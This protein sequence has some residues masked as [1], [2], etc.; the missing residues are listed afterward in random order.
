MYEA[1]LC[2]SILVRSN[3]INVG[4]VPVRDKITSFQVIAICSAW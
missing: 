1:Q 4:E 3:P 2:G